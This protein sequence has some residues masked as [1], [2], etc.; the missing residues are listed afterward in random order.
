M[1]TPLRE[2]ML[3]PK[4]EPKPIKGTRKPIATICFFFISLFLMLISWNFPAIAQDSAQA[5]A[6]TAPVVTTQIDAYGKAIGAVVT[7]LSAIFGLPIVFLTYRKTRAEIAKLELEAS[8]L[9]EKQSVGPERKKD[10]EGNIRI[11]IEN[12]SGV[13]IKV[14]ADPRFLAPLLLLVDF[15]FAWVALTLADKLFAIFTAGIV[16]AGIIA[17]FSTVLLLPIAKQV[18]R[19]RAVLSPPRSTEELRSSLRQTRIAVYVSYLLVVITSILFGAIVLLTAS[20]DALTDAGSTLALTSIS[21]G[22][23]LIILA[24]RLRKKFNKYIEYTSKGL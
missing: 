17:L 3:R 10:A 22:A 1:P 23:L 13:N 20:R 18:L 24:P 7:A 16:H 4:F 9:R 21:I 19:V 5:T 15:I 14:L 6:T 12:S 8:A 2:N 11:N